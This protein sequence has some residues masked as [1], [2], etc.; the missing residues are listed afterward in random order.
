MI[1]DRFA[2]AE[3]FHTK[4]HPL[5]KSDW[6][7]SIVTLI[8]NAVV[9]LI[10]VYLWK[11]GIIN[12]SGTQNFLFITI[13]L[14]ALILLMDILMYIFHFIAHI[15]LIYKLIHNKHHQHINTNFLSLFVL[16]PLETFGFGLMM[17]S[18][19]FIF[20]FSIYA[21]SSYIFI[22]LFFGT[23]R[24]LNREFF[25]RWADK[26]FIG[27]SRFHNQHHLDEQY[28]FGFYTTIWDRVFGTFKKE[29]EQNNNA[30]TD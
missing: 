29:N 23:I 11:T 9:F 3:N 13:Q 8:V 2:Q 10:A 19:L 27:T 28:N 30:T 22:N 7:I 12:I 16:H 24:H 26:L 15:P 21:I 20:D 1:F 4:K 14:I 5:L 6:L 18:T 25:P 17:I